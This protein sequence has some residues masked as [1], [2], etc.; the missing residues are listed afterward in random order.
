V[1]AS[2]LIRRAVELCAHKK[3]VVVSMSGFAAS[4][5][6]WVST[7]AARVFADPGTLTGS[8]GVLGGKF[9]VAGA[10]AALGINSGE[11]SRGQNAN[12]F[13]SFTDFTPAQARIFHDQI[14]GDTYKYFLQIVAKQRRMTIDQVNDLAQGRVWT[15]AQAAHNK[16][17]DQIGGFDAA[18][19]EAKILARLDP[20]EPVQIEELPAPPGL[21]KRILGGR[22]DGE[23]GWRPPAA[24]EPLFWMMRE[25][26]A[27]HGAIGA[28]YCPLVPV[29]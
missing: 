13:D 8:I 12:I 1:I 6:F 27:R 11:V 29:M 2:E 22:L 15:G 9:N 18:L 25:S 4:G 24:L 17:I 23:A 21:L 10:A 19:S 7:P 14:L 3:P 20:R 28:A 26:L 5:G 16:L